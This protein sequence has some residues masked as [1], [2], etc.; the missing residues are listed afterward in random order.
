M[1]YDGTFPGAYSQRTA[2]KWRGSLKVEVVG[3]LRAPLYQR[4]VHLLGGAEHLGRGRALYRSLLQLYWCRLA[5]G[6]L[7]L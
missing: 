5:A 1:R 7:L 6:L 2:S 4:D 3:A